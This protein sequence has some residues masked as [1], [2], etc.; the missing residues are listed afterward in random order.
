MDEKVYVYSHF[1]DERFGINFNSLEKTVEKEEISWRAKL[2]KLNKN[3]KKAK[4]RYLSWFKEFKDK[5]SKTN[6]ILL[7]KKL[8]LLNNILKKL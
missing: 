5:E 3:D 6:F 7:N 4:E 8:N 1:W 2:I